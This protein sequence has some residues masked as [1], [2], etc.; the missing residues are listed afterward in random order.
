MKTCLLFIALL[1]LAASAKALVPLVPSDSGISVRVG[2]TVYIESFAKPSCPFLYST[3]GVTWAYKDSTNFHFFQNFGLVFS[4]YFVPKKVG[5]FRDTFSAKVSYYSNQQ[6]KCKGTTWE[7]GPLPVVYHGTSDSVIDVSVWTLDEQMRY[8]SLQHRYVSKGKGSLKFINNVNDITRFQISCISDS[9]TII[10]KIFVILD[11]NSLTEISLSPKTRRQYVACSFASDTMPPHH[12]LKNTFSPFRFVFH[13]T[14]SSFDSTFVLSE[15]LYFAKTP[16]PPVD[17]GIAV[18]VGDTVDGKNDFIYGPCQIDDSKDHILINYHDHTNFRF[19]HYSYAPG[20]QVL[21]TPQKKGLFRDTVT[22][23]ISYQSNVFSCAGITWN[24]GPLP[25][26]YHAISDSVIRMIPRFSYTHMRYDSLTRRY[27]STE[28]SSFELMN[29]VEDSTLFS[30]QLLPNTNQLSKSVHVEF[31]SSKDSTTKL[32][33]RVRRIT[34]NCNFTTDTMP[35]FLHDTLVKYK[36]NC[37]MK[38]STTDSLFQW[39]GS[40]LYFDSV[41]HFTSSVPNQSEEVIQ[42]K[43][44]ISSSRIIMEFELSNPSPIAL[45]IS[46]IT[47][48]TIAHLIDGAFYQPGQHHLEYTPPFSSGQYFL[49][50]KTKD[51]T[52]VV[53]FSYLK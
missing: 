51:G 12:F 50:Y 17:S 1:S 30:C 14:N 29:N 7:S 36:L 49:T 5:L 21:F 16:D 47:G 3:D 32:T 41:V 10:K 48:K 20:V 53:P 27:R 44:I 52:K 35:P 38:N 24:S 45:S 39:S 23:S 19:I 34:A 42:P 8:D 18:M 31:D 15:F 26:V 9:Q 13:A 4:A 2:D 25:F 6:P 37:I 33:P 43:I 22:I 46:D 40:T 28:Q 11:T